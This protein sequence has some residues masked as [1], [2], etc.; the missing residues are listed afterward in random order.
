MKNKSTVNQLSTQKH[1]KRLLI[2]WTTLKGLTAV[3]IF[4]IIATLIEYIV[5]LYAMNLGLKEKPESLLQ[6][7][8]Q[9]P[10]TNWT[11]TIAIS[12]I[13]Y[14]VP[15]AVIITLVFS[16][17]YL[18]R[19]ITL[20]PHEI[21]RGKV[22]P[23][24][25][26][27]KE[28]KLKETRKI[29]GRIKSGLLRVKGVTYLWQKIHFARATI[30]SAL[31]VILIFLVFIFIIS[32]LAYPQLI[33]LTVSN[34]YKN[35]PSLLNFV[36]GTARSLAPIGEFFSVINNALL[37]A[38]PA[39]RGFVL[40]LGTIIKPLVDLDSVGKYLVFQNVAAWVS[41]LVALLYGEYTRKGY[42]YKKSRKS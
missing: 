10:G 34:A 20:K 1:S 42:R 21:H 22:A 41:G 38:A 6:W 15:L 9:F 36:K 7:S 27:G 30:K 5:V 35:D 8:F 28:Q 14:L 23:Q 12:P 19:C 26:R 2:R 33:Y 3:I 39:I 24:P 37:S 40:G 17:T 4:L 11:I 18:T 13:F 25:K 31:T 16:W 32:L 29:F